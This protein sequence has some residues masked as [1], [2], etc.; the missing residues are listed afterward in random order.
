MMDAKEKRTMRKEREGREKQHLL[1][2]V[3]GANRVS[4]KRHSFRAVPGRLKQFH[5]TKEQDSRVSDG[6]RMH[7]HCVCCR[8]KAEK[9]ED[10][11]V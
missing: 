5:Q 3:A 10:K 9:L 2:K 1:V 6:V 11:R 8:E 7:N 4:P